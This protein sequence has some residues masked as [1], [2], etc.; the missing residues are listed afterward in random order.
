[1]ILIDTSAWAEFLRATGS[2]IHRRVRALVVDEA[3]IVTTDVVL[4]EILAGARDEADANGLRRLL[5]RYELVPVEGLIDFEAAASIYRTCRRGGS[6]IRT[7]VDCL[8]AA[9]AIRTDAAVLHQDRDFEAIARH[10]P[11]RLAS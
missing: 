8:I 5:Y 1:V 9:V 11:L 6:T 2:A 4:M 3:D 10:T 7:L